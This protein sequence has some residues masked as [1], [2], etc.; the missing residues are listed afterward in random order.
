MEGGG[1]THLH[2]LPD[3]LHLPGSGDRLAALMVL[4]EL[5]LAPSDVCQERLQHRTPRLEGFT[6]N[7]E[8][9]EPVGPETYPRGDRSPRNTD[10]VPWTQN[11]S[12]VEKWKDME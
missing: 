8:A 12:R 11:P 6:L 9:A 5:H 10:M 3:N 7:P 4:L 1:A 2:C